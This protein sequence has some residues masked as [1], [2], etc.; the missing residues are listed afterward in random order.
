[1]ETDGPFLRRSEACLSITLSQRPGRQ[2]IKNP[3]WPPHA[4]FHNTQ[5]ILMGFYLGVLAIAIRID[6]RV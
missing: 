1:M 4:K 3:N 2:H 6:H 5:T